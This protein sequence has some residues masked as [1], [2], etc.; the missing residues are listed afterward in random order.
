MPRCENLNHIINMA[1]DRRASDIHF[2]PYGSF[3]K[4]DIGLMVAYEYFKI[5]IEVYGT[6]ATRLKVLA[7]MD[8][9]EKRAFQDGK[10]KYFHTQG[11]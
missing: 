8:I 9:S 4:L 3:F 7:Q 6:V 10:Y 11:V 1:I 5:P 2:E